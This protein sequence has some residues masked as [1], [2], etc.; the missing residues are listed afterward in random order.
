MLEP[1]ELPG[2]GFS[3]VFHVA[4]FLLEAVGVFDSSRLRF[5]F[6]LLL[7]SV[8]VGTLSSDCSLND[9]FP[10]DSVGCHIMTFFTLHSGPCRLCPGATDLIW[11]LIPGPVCPFANRPRYILCTP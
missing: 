6:C 10:Q 2:Q 7:F 3:V 9:D 8:I 1:T 4:A 5:S 11:L